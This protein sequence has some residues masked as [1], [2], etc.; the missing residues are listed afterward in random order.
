MNH[1]LRCS[2]YELVKPDIIRAEGCYLYDAQ[3]R[4]FVD[5]EAGVWCAALGHSH[6]RIKGQYRGSSSRRRT[7]GTGTRPL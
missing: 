4:R 6:R 3:D 5:L 1:V 2:G 7:S